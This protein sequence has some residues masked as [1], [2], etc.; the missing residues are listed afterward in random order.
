MEAPLNYPIAFF[1]GSVMQSALLVRKH[2]VTRRYLLVLTAPLLMFAFV[3][4]YCELFIDGNN[5]AHLPV[6]MFLVTSRNFHR[7]AGAERSTR[8]KNGNCE[9]S[10]LTAVLPFRNGLSVCSAASDHAAN[11]HIFARQKRTFR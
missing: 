6:R 7:A 5:Q 3:F 4:G 1:L 9:F 2:G 10:D 8:G 11:F